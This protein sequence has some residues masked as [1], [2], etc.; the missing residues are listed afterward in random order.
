M[1]AFS[2]KCMMIRDNKEQANVGRRS[3]FDL[4]NT[5]PNPTIF[6]TFLHV[7]QSMFLFLDKFKI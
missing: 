2:Q 6:K 7:P 3:V 5:K 1:W 4:H